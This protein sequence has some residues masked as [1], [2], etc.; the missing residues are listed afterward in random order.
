MRVW[1]LFFAKLAVTALVPPL[2]A[3]ETIVRVTDINPGPR[4]SFP[5]FLT[6]FQNQ[7]YFRG[8]TGLLDTE[9]WRFDGTNAGRAADIVPGPNGSTPSYLTV[10]NG[11]LYFDATTAA[12]QYRLHRFDG[13]AATALNTVPVAFFGSGSWQPVVWGGELWFRSSG[14]IYRFN[15]SSFAY[16]NTPPWAN[17]EPVLFNGSLYYGA[18]DAAFGDELWRFNGAAQARVTD[19]VAGSGDAYPEALHVWRGALYF[20]ARDGA[21]GNE[22]WR[23]DGATAQRVADIRPGPADSNPSGFAG[24]RDALYFAADDGVHGY[25]LFRFDD[26]GVTLAA[27]INPN[28]IYHQGGDPLSDS[29]P[30][31]LTVFND[32]LYFIASSGTESGLW[33]YDGTN[34]VVLGGGSPNG[35]TELLVCNNAL[36][37][38]ADD[39]VFGRE[40]WRVEPAPEPRLDIAPAAADQVRLQLSEAESGTYVIES[41]TDFVNWTP[42]ATNRAVDGQV[43]HRDRTNGTTRAYRT[44][45]KN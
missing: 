21:S 34:A 45:K 38:D 39:G 2:L 44:V 33:R 42:V 6:V 17:S 35:V 26:Q 32:A 24:F 29:N 27:D 13:A 22:L 9:L 18:Q 36:Y 25:E 14:R 37:F 16:L 10:L 20:R 31:A 43:F 7:L 40:L 12:G 4:G 8:N 5:S 19:L 23:Y 11:H 3:A 1:I 28:P 41:S 15:G 30:R